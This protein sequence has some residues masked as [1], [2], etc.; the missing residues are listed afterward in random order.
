LGA[1]I[2]LRPER[3]FAIGNQGN[4][5][6]SVSWGE[7]SDA[8]C[9]ALA[10]SLDAVR[11][12]YLAWFD[13]DG[14]IVGCNDAMAQFL[15]LNPD[16]FREQGIW[17]KLTDSDS[18]RLRERMMAPHDSGGPLLLNFAT[19][20]Q[21]IKT[22]SCGLAA[23][24]GGGFLMAGAPPP[25]TTDDSEI[26][27]MQLNNSFALLSRENAR[28]SK[29]LERRND[30]LTKTTEALQ[31]ANQA[32]AEARTA[33][34]QAAQAK[35]DFLSHMS[36][37]IRTPMNGVI[38]MVQLLLASDLTPQQRRYAEI[39]QA[40]G[41]TLLALIDDILDLSKIEAGKIKVESL[42]FDLV[43]F[44]EDFGE[45][46]RIPA[47]AKGVS[48]RL[49]LL[50]GTPAGLR[51][52][53]NRL[54]QILNNLTANALKFTERGEVAILVERVGE[55][56]GKTTLRFSVMDTGIGIRPEQAAALFSPFT[57]ADVSTTRKY[58]GTGLGLAI[59]KQLVELM[60]GTIG[61]ESRE[62]EGSTFWFTV[63]F[64]MSKSVPMPAAALTSSSPR[65]PQERWLD[66]RHVMPPDAATGA[67]KARILVAEDNST[68]QAVIL[69]QLEMLGYTA[70]VVA[71]GAEAVEALSHTTYDLVFMDCEM[72]TMDGYQATRHIRESGNTLVPIVALTAS[73]MPDDRQRCLRAGMNGFLSKPLELRRLE[74]V[75]T[76]WLPATDS[77]RAVLSG[78]AP[79]TE[80]TAAIFDSQ[81]LLRRMMGDRQLVRKILNGFLGGFPAQV[82]DL[83]SR[84]ADA[85]G[86]AVRLRAHTVR[87]SAATV[88]ANAL[89]AIAAD[90]ERA[91]NA[92]ELDRAGDLVL[93]MIEEFERLKSTVENTGWL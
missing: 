5:E 75:L 26:A 84:L 66:G 83:R 60:G 81:A 64:E 78:H 6:D 93:R 68:N 74:E 34:L 77:P 63:V 72:P 80:E 92:G 29:Q 39:A 7:W 13:S 41:K 88:A 19:S 15:G 25:S 11:H 36:H 76:Q 49:R 40:S 62:G 14:Q 47:D 54:R 20:N 89:S 32:L 91:A 65:E 42:D 61:L 1:A 70:D 69:G 17:D 46:W 50:P 73:A 67:H 16:T 71:N 27:W 3:D 18:L 58:G 31:L 44:V 43:R 28:K 2:A 85:D 12:I 57:Q 55:Q 24:S 86:A 90:I 56:E 23:M 33:A 52:D 30:E 51:G 53:P 45:V 4:S 9:Q 38:G 35:A 59:S 21:N 37:E 48:F 22:L 10:G 87:G 79:A 8:C 82:N